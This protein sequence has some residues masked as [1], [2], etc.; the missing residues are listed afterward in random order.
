MNDP[1]IP[2]HELLDFPP[3]ALYL[4]GVLGALNEFRQ[5]PSMTLVFEIKKCIYSS[6]EKALLSMENW[7]R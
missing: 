2:P 6:L 7:A 5:F 3:L 1:S 4:N